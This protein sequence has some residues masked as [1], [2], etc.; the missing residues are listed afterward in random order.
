MASFKVARGAA[1][2]R[3]SSS[4]KCKCE[5]FMRE[6]RGKS[7]HVKEDEHECEAQRGVQEI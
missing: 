6:V 5:R 7:R 1:Y 2:E 3:R 4:G